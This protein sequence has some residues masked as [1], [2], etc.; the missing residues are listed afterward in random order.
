MNNFVDKLRLREM[1]E[2][3]IYFA[4]RDVELIEALRKK[5]RAKSTSSDPG[6]TEKKKSTTSFDHDDERTADKHK[7]EPRRLIDM[8]REY[9]YEI[10]GVLGRSRR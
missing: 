4:K 2:E 8:L 3:D 6:N 7:K 1:A 9:V 5:K 10:A